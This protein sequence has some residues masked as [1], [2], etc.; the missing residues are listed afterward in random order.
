MSLQSQT[1]GDVG[2][3]SGGSVLPAPRFHV[4]CAPPRVLLQSY[5]GYIYSELVVELARKAW[6]KVKDKKA[7]GEWSYTIPDEI[8]EA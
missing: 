2:E 6:K 1:I 5:S 4:G 7:K 8:R 3:A